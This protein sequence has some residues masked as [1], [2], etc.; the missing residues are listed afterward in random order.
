MSQPNES[1]PRRALGLADMMILVAAT[2]LALV[3][4]RKPLE[5][6]L[7]FIADG[8]I[9][10]NLRPST[11]VG[12]AFAAT[13]GLG[14]IAI[15]LR[16]I[17]RFGTG[18]S[19]RPGFVACAAATMGGAF[20]LAALLVW[21]ASENYRFESWYVPSVLGQLIEP[22]A[23]AVAGGWLT[24]WLA[25]LWKRER[26]LVDDLGIFIGLL[27]LALELFAWAALCLE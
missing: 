22:A 5:Y 1:Q 25:G 10:E 27:W 11:L 12:A 26:S 23:M 2:A 8:R 16:S 21:G 9:I 7:T 14:I 4:L 18:W 6:R 15:R 20:K 17:T 3:W 24:L 19:Y 13:W